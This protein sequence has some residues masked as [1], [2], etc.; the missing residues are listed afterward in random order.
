MRDTIVYPRLRKLMGEKNVY[1][2]QI[3]DAL[4]LNRVTAG[5]KL[6][7]RYKLYLDEAMAIQ[8]LFFPDV[9]LEDLFGE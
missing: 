9:S 6:S 3:A 7:G 5:K 1:I 2:Y 8:R 4:Q